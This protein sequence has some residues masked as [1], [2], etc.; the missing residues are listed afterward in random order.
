MSVRNV[1]LSFTF[2]SSQLALADALST[3]SFGIANVSINWIPAI[4]QVGDAAGQTAAITESTSGTMICHRV[5][6]AAS[7]FSV[8]LGAG[9]CMQTS[10]QRNFARA[11]SGQVMVL[12]YPFSARARSVG[13]DK[14]LRMRQLSFSNFYIEGITG[15][16]KFTRGEV[17]TPVSYT[18]DTLDAGLGIG[19]S[20]RF[21]RYSAIGLETSYLYGSSLSTKV[22]SGSTSVLAM[23]GTLTVFL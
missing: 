13:D 22:A 9:G 16:S 15:F 2:L 20:Y 5:S 14:A 6:S 1:L 17:I 8:E 7:L 23:V 3:T 21:F 18:V 4:E 12:Y 10:D 11:L 19:Y